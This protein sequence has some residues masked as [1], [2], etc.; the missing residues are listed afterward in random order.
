MTA[1]RQPLMAGVPDELRQA[2]CPPVL[3]AAAAPTPGAASPDVTEWP[4][5]PPARQQERPEPPMPDT[6]RVIDLD[7]TEDHADEAT[8]LLT[9]H[10]ACHLL[11]ASIEHLRT[12]LETSPDRETTT[13]LQRSIGRASEALHL[14]DDLVRDPAGA[15]ETPTSRT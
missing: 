7:A 2:G 14:L 15:V 9:A 1:W 11:E 3:A 6:T 12:A 5:A 8:W 4:P 10:R 13:R